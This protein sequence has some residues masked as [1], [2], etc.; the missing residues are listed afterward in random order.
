MAKVLEIRWHARGGQGAKTA[1]LML[2]ESVAEM[3]KYVQ[4]FPEYGPERMGAPIQAFNRISDEP[5]YIHSN[6]IN[7]NIVIVLDPTLIG[8]AN[9]TE[10]V[11]EDGIYIINTTKTPAEVR[12]ML[13]IKS[14][15]I[16]T[17]D[18]N[19][20]SLET[21]GRAIPNTPMMGAFIRA[22]GIIPFDQFMTHMREQL[23][24]KFKSKPEVIEGNLKAIERA[25]REVNAE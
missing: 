12:E 24:K 9:V 4:G 10:G 2:A 8:K 11:P 7:P 15:K 16:Y 13:G 14:G 22:T 5:I 6:V 20:I 21:I 17:L 18:A 25:Y 1:A 19:Q 23:S 3:G